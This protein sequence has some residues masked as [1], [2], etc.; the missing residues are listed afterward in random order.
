MKGHLD[1]HSQGTGSTKNK[2]PTEED[3]EFPFELSVNN[4]TRTHECFAALIPPT[5]LI[6]TDQTGRFVCPSETGNNYLMVLYDY[7]SNAILAEA[8]PNRTKQSLLTAFKKL[9]AQLCAVGLRPNYQC[10]DNE[11]SNI[12]KQFMTA[13]GIKYQ[14]VP[15]NKAPPQCRRTSHPHAQKPP[16]RQLLQP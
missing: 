14:F 13:Q 9:H 10:L 11:C 2:S 8:I 16:H 5:G 15:P 7:D 12:M 6:Y 1:Q 4:E 3:F